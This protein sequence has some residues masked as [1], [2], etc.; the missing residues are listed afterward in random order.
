[1][2]E[3]E[4]KS[5]TDIS[6]TAGAVA[7]KCEDIQELGAAALALLDRGE[8]AATSTSATDLAEDTPDLQSLAH[9]PPN[10]A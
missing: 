10:L 9:K 7:G 8:C 2:V 6:R 1:M 5:L 4:L 3:Q